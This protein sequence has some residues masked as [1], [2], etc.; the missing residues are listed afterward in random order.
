MLGHHQQRA[1]RQREGVVPAQLLLH[2][3]KCSQFA[4]QRGQRLVVEGA[5]GDAQLRRPARQHLARGLDRSDLG[6]H[7]RQ[8]I[9][10]RAVIVGRAG[11]RLEHP[12]VE[13]PALWQAQTELY[14]A[15]ILVEA[16]R[17]GIVGI[18]TDALV[19][20]R[21]AA[22][23]GVNQLDRAVPE[24]VVEA[25]TGTALGMALAADGQRTV[26]AQALARLGAAG[27]DLHHAADR[28]AAVQAGERAAHDLDAL[29]VAQR[30]VVEVGLAERR[31]TV[32]Y[33]IDQQQ[34][35]TRL[36]AAHEDRAGLAQTAIGGELDARLLR[37]HLGQR[38]AGLE[39]QILGGQHRHVGDAAVGLDRAAGGGHHHGGQRGR[40][41]GHGRGGLGGSAQ[42]QTQ[43]QRCGGSSGAQARFGQTAADGEL[44][45]DG[46][47]SGSCMPAS[48][49]AS[50]LM[51][52]RRRDRRGIDR[53]P[54][55]RY[56]G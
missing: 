19:R 24:A 29:D 10:S 39:R 3:G 46:T 22:V 42:R 33:A 41:G 40:R 52:R 15:G 30:Q 53:P 47:V 26:A 45:H 13:P 36:H 50:H 5:A 18:R 49:Q 44:G 2:G 9:H 12:G 27:E 32:A 8:R 38:A 6:T 54:V 14:A 37:Q 4:P 55:G 11:I 56:P 25:Q 1:D 51:A 43:H 7:T 21:E 23:L 16:I 48:P 28:I 34:H 17:V 31:R 35:M 20:R